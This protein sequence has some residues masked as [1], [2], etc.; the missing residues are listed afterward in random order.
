M[1]QVCTGGVAPGVLTPRF[2]ANAAPGIPA[3]PPPVDPA[4]LAQQAYQSLPIRKPVM[5]FGPDSKRVA[6]NYWLYLWV[7]NPGPLTATANAGVVTVTATATLSSV[8]WTMGEPVSAT[9]LHA[10]APAIT[11]GPGIDPGPNVDTAAAQPLAGACAYQYHVRSTPDRTNG[12]DTWPVTAAATWTVA[13][14]VTA[15]VG[16]TAGATTGTI[17]PPAFVS[18]TNLCVGAWSTVEVADGYTPA[19]GHCGSLS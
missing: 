8:I 15:G 1:Q 5:H 11:C 10:P 12:T 18:T 13:W 7:D 19:A 4:V 14:T 6:V 16:G 3:A 9:D 2:V 17:T